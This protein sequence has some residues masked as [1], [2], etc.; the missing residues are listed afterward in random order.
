[1]AEIKH[2]TCRE[3]VAELDKYIIGQDD[4]KRA[5]AIA[6]RNRWRRLRLAA[7]IREEVAPKNIIMIGPTGVGKTEI[8]R[9]LA[10]LVGAPFIK[11]EAT[12]FT[13]VGYVGRDVDGIIRDLLE[14]AIQMVHGEQAEVHGEQA[15][16]LA[17]E[18][19]LDCLLPRPAAAPSIDTQQIQDQHERYQ[20]TRDKLRRQLQDGQLEQR[21][22]EITVE[23]RSS[24]IPII[25]NVGLDQMEPEMQ[26]FLER[27]MPSRQVRRQV[28][29]A[30]ARGILFQQEL[31]K[32]IDREKMIDEAIGRTEQAGMVFLDEIDKVCGS[33]SFGPDVS[34]EGVQRDLLPLVEGTTVNT[35]HGLVRTDHILFIAAG[36]FSRNKPSDLM[37][38]LQGRFPIRVRLRDLDSGHFRRIL[39][40]P[41]NAL[42]KQQEAL[43]AT[44]GIELTFTPDG[45][46]ALADKAYELNKSQQNIGA[47]RLYAV[48]EKVLEEISFVAPDGARKYVIDADY[49]QQHLSRASEDED[50]NVFGFAAARRDEKK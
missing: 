19:I 25:S 29:V 36:A 13:E 40:E 3:V 32:L 37:P 27:M 49:V 5:V 21:Q 15:R 18:R 9:R 45:I 4:A 2:L 42:S 10:A 14:R 50:L 6:V 20:R 35:R 39:V 24:A 7:E 47:R 48:M 23:E 38:E 22:I 31:E 46:A 43:L 41:R 16:H 12:K 11:V 30:E 17:S 1:M 28:S 8:A 26:N 44:E 34:R 33:G